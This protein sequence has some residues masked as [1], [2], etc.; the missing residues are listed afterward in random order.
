MLEWHAHDAPP[1]GVV[2]VANVRRVVGHQPQFELGRK[3]KRLL[4]QEAGRDLV[5]AG[6]ALE[7]A[8][9]EALALIDLDRHYESG[10]PQPGDVVPG[11]ADVAPGEKGLEV[12]RQRVVPKRALEGL[13]EC[14]LTGRAGA[15]AKEELLLA[16]VA[17]E[18][19]TGCTLEER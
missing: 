9:R 5:S 4:V 8:L 6:Q 18:G 13:G 17:G 1:H 19:P 7:Q 11:A 15:D 14:A 16:R 10:P 3:L 12:G 2:V